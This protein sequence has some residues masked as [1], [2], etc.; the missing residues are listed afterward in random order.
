MWG[1]GRSPKVQ[2]WHKWGNEG[3]RE[4]GEGWGEEGRVQVSAVGQWRFACGGDWNV[5]S[6]QAEVVTS[7]CQTNNLLT[8]IHG[9]HGSVLKNMHLVAHSFTTNTVLHL[10]YWFF[11]CEIRLCV[12]QFF[13]FIYVCV[14]VCVCVH[15]SKRCILRL[16][17]VKSCHR[18]CR[19]PLVSVELSD[20]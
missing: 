15:A 17:S 4:G 8:Q 10:S 14:C 13:R 5:S 19:R 9:L 2:G 12:L 18:S 7:E 3:W 11:M 6:Q 16:K 1:G 20:G